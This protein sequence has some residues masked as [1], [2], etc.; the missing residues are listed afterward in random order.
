[1]GRLYYSSETFLHHPSGNFAGT[2]DDE[3]LLVGHY[4]LLSRETSILPPLRWL[5]AIAT[6]EAQNAAQRLEL[7]AIFYFFEQQR[8]DSIFENV[9][10]M[11]DVQHQKKH[12]L[13]LA[14][15]ARQS[16]GGPQL[17][18]NHLEKN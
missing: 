12:M 17:P 3:P 9:H 18:L 14:A 16:G 7:L 15:L 11:Q 13:R 10:T 4:K 2:D 8:P 6:N 5:L 1:M